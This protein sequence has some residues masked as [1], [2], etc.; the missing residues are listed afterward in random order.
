MQQLL[1]VLLQIIGL[2]LNAL[3][4]VIVV[5]VVLSWLFSFQIVSPREPFVGQIW[6]LTQVI[7]EPLLRP[8]RRILP[9]V[10]GFDFSPAVLLI[11]VYLIQSY[12]LP[13]LAFAL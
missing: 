7:T 3:I 5:Q 6:R 13:H 1:L 9:P 2:L 12:L 4:V 11:V 8:I 10:S